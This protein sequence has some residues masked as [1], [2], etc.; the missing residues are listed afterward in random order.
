MTFTTYLNNHKKSIRISLS[1]IRAIVSLLIISPAV[2]VHSAEGDVIEDI[3]LS[4]LQRTDPG[5]IFSKI[6][7]AVGDAFDDK[8]ISD[9]IR[10]LFKTGYFSNIE[11]SRDGNV[12]V[13][14]VRER[15]AIASISFYGL[16]EFKEEQL[17]SALEAEGLSEGAIL[18]PAKLDLAVQE[19][20]EA[21]L[22][23]GKY[24]VEISSTITPLERNRVGVSFS[25][26]EGMRAGINSIEFFG[27]RVFSKDELL[28]QM[29]L[30]S[31]SVFFGRDDYSRIKLEADLEAIR[32]FYLNQGYINFQIVNSQV[33]VGP[34]KQEISIT[35]SVEEGE[36]FSFG[37][38]LLAGDEIVS[39]DEL[40]AF[41]DV[42]SGDLFSRARVNELVNKISD[43]L[44]DDG[45]ANANVRAIPQL[46]IERK[47]VSFT[48]Y[49][50]A[51]R[52]LYVR[53]INISGN[54]TTQDTVIR[55]ELRQ[56][57]GEWYSLKRINRSKQRLDLTG[58]FSS[59]T[60]KSSP[61]LGLSDTVDLD[62]Q[63][64]ERKTGSFQIGLGY[65]DTD[66]VLMSVGLTNENIFG[67]GNSLN[68]NIISGSVN[69]TYAVKYKNPYTNDYGVSRTLN[70]SSR[71][72]DY[73]SLNI[74]TYAEDTLEV[75]V[76]YGIPLSEYDDIFLGGGIEES[77]IT[78]GTDPSAEY[79]SFVNRNG[80]RNITIPFNIGW[81]RDRRDS[82][83]IPSAGS[84]QRF[85]SSV[86]TPLGDLSFYT[87]NYQHKAYRALGKF[88]T[89]LASGSVFFAEDYGGDQLP[90]YK[91]SYAGGASTL[92]GYQASALGPK[93]S[94]GTTLGGKR[95]VL[96]SLEMLT[97]VPGVKDDK[98]IRLITFLDAGG[99]ANS[100]DGVFSDYRYSVGVGVNWYS[101]VGP[102]KLSFSKA[103]NSKADDKTEIV[104]FTLGGLF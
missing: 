94:D 89:F 59:V 56:F 53:R 79:S 58:F 62:V 103:L 21:Y 52:R 77:D 98:T 30:S 78:L 44:G 60:I 7:V 81:M 35:I 1:L 99:L 36:R 12:L 41:V 100:F 16:K 70:F 92:R 95:R 48:I 31:S 23:K 11:A 10:L 4:G 40:S 75:S 76:D 28:D 43:R 90:F 38:V 66:R 27:N 8:I 19:L 29:S 6:P 104:Q 42:R 45:Y 96:T 24:G 91:N 47:I 20:K 69:E 57:E 46:D 102:M 2:A 83:I 67:S 97:P 101:P 61:V 49:I 54:I 51:G 73:S 87:L 26:F 65:S 88:T 39:F 82:A 80:N 71:K 37:D 5:V 14:A 34:D 17:R 50:D 93:R 15:P 22:S 32:S 25:V 72:S 3:R 86:A 85:N 68:L 18:D 55:R 84:L 74:A 63:V 64:V 9:T 33:S 13:I